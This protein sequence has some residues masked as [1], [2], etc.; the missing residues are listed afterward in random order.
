MT[1]IWTP[2]DP[3]NNKAKTRSIY[4]TELQVAANV[5]RV[6]IAQSQ[7]SFINQNI[8]KEFVLGAIEELKTVTNQLAIDFGYSTGVE[9]P[10]LLGR[11][12]VTITK[13]Y[14]KAVCHYPILNDLRV[15]LNALEIQAG[16]IFA[17]VLEHPTLGFDNV[18]NLG[19]SNGPLDIKYQFEPQFGSGYLGANGISCD[20]NYI[21]RLHVTPTIFTYVYKDNPYT[22][23][24]D[25][26]KVITPWQATD[27]TVDENY[28][29]LIGYIYIGPGNYNWQIK[30]LLKSNLT[31]LNTHTPL[32]QL[33][34]GYW[35]MCNDKDTLYI[36]GVNSSNI[37][38]IRKY[39]KSDFSYIAYSVDGHFV[40]DINRYTRINDA[41]I[42]D[43]YIYVTYYEENMP[44]L[45]PLEKVS[46][47]LKLNKSSMTLNTIIEKYDN[48]AISPQ[49]FD[50][51]SISVS[52]DYIYIIP[53]HYPAGVYKVVVYNKSGGVLYSNEF[54]AGQGVTDKESRHLV[55]NLEEYQ[56]TLS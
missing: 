19:I 46:A 1:F 10:L 25:T 15:V 16:L 12:Y 36:T 6:E 37:S 13:K 22:G 2:P 24:N 51:S 50:Y 34:G 9:D 30:K 33:S 43:S 20:V 28:V 40:P 53:K 42:D 4:M 54:V 56:V 14:G 23:I 8:G 26:I 47:I 44:L 27:I 11:P 38:E 29:W 7:L 31:V 55:C 17:Y 39:S 48:L 35:A 21:Y 45:P 18:A 49:P 3:L 41:S 52:K 5:K 32:N